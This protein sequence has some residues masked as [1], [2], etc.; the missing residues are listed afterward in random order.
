MRK[1]FLITMIIPVALLA[2]CDANKGTQKKGGDGT[3]QQ[4][5]AIQNIGQTEALPMLNDTNVVTIDVRTSGEVLE[6][7]IDGADLFIDVNGDFK[8]QIAT[9]D[10]SKTYLVY[11]RSGGRSSTAAKM[12]EAEGFNSIYNLSGGISSWSGPVKP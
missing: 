7:Y 12:M 6:G 3:E 5:P 1:L 8:S 2:S 10:K 9:L 4:A 11:C